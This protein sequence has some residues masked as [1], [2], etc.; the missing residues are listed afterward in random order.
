MQSRV[1]SRR[2]SNQEKHESSERWLLTYADLI[3]LLLAF[4]VIMYG[5]SSADAKKFSRLAESMRRAFNVDILEGMPGRS[6][7]EQSMDMSAVNVADE[8]L[9]NAEIAGLETLYGTVS[10]FL[11]QKGL[12]DRVEMSLRS[13]GV[14]ISISGNMLFTSGRAELRPDAVDLLHTLGQALA[15]LSNQIRVEGHTDDVA[16]VGTDYPTNWELSGARSVSVVRWLAEIEGIDP[17]RLSAAAYS[18]FR[19]AVA[20]DSPRGRS[21]N[22][23][24]EI[25]VMYSDALTGSMTDLQ[26]ASNSTNIGGIG[27]VSGTN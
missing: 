5:M 7:M 19:P 6:I 22:R 11:E 24:S 13:D 15:P 14:A 17:G 21:K 16:P 26:G 25:L 4:F 2:A 23:R 12:T 8:A 9:I 27:S 18:E 1:R 10:D 3:T 20:N